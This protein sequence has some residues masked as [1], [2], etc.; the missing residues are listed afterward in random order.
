MHLSLLHDL[1]SVLEGATIQILTQVN[2][3]IKKKTPSVTTYIWIIVHGGHQALYQGLQ[4]PR[5]KVPIL[6][7]RVHTPLSHI[8]LHLSTTTGT[9][10]AGKYWRLGHSFLQKQ[11]KK[12][13]RRKLSFRS[14]CLMC[15]FYRGIH[16]TQL[17][18]WLNTAWEL[19]LNSESKQSHVCILVLAFE[20]H[21][22]LCH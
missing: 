21:F 20:M 8:W 12:E 9:K 3:R 13:K 15:G 19:M 1:E 4:W 7:N 14:G 2:H 6:I 22:K 18:I 11:K 5:N 16:L 10:H 17:Y